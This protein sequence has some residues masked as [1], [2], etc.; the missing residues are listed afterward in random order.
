M[1]AS[2]RYALFMMPFSESITLSLHDD[3]S[4][5]TRFATIA[6]MSVHECMVLKQIGCGFYKWKQSGLD[7]TPCTG[8]L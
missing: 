2:V 4:A 7:R 8:L 3:V 1:M 6:K 5:S